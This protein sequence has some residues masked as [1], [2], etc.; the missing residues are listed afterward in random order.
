M[1]DANAICYAAR[2]EP[3]IAILLKDLASGTNNL[4]NALFSISSWCRLHVGLCFLGI[5]R[6]C[7]LDRSLLHVGSPGTHARRFQIIGQ[8]DG[9]TERR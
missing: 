3:G 2:R 7:L 8:P 9:K 5:V 1:C 6:D 4:P